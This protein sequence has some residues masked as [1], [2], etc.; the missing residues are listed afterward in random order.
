MVF[1]RSVMIRDQAMHLGYAVTIATRYSAVRRQGGE[2]E[3]GH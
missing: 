2:L 1:V 3:P